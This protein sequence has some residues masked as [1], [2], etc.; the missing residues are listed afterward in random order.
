MCSAGTL[1]AEITKQIG[2]SG[3]VVTQRYALDL[4]VCKPGET[5]GSFEEVERFRLQQGAQTTVQYEEQP[6]EHGG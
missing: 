1:Q 6:A 3:E 2:A 4:V 5:E